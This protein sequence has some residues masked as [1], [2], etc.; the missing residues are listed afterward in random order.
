MDLYA[1]A[2][3]WILAPIWGSIRVVLVLAQSYNGFF[4]TIEVTLGKIGDTLPRFKVILLYYAYPW[5][6]KGFYFCMSLSFS[7]PFHDQ[8]SD[9]CRYQEYQRLFPNGQHPGLAEALSVV[10]LDI[11]TL[12]IEFRALIRSQTSSGI[13]RLVQP[14]RS[15]LKRKCKAA[16]GRFRLHKE[17]VE[18]IAQICHMIEED[19]DRQE[20]RAS[21]ELQVTKT[22]G[23]HS[24]S[25]YRER[26]L[27][28]LP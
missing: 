24:C 18:K 11:I 3:S 16:L 6:L 22:K 15:S 9:V 13:N 5:L 23:F 25:S 27:I 20:A 7:L 1:N 2:A 8:S 21:R 14:L 12:C 26:L 17:N 19:K 4:E 10:Y 28:F